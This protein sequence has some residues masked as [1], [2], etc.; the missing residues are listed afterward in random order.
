[1]VNKRGI[2]TKPEKI[3]ALLDMSLP[4]KPKEVM[5]LVGKVAVLS[6]FVSRATHRCAPFFNA[7]RGSKQFKWTEKCEHA[8]QDL[9]KHLGQPA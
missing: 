5:S 4:H 6:R 8:F 3:K 9:K 7:L 1:M 2:E